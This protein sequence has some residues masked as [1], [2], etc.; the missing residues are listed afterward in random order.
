MATIGDGGTSYVDPAA[1]VAGSSNQSLQ[2]EL[3][4]KSSS[5]KRPLALGSEGVEVWEDIGDYMKVRNT[6]VWL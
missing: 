2:A 3:G 6:S 4:D 1:S 5:C